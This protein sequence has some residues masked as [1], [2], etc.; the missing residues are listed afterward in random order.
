MQKILLI[1]AAV[2]V[3]GGGVYAGKGKLFTNKSDQDT[4]DKFIARAEKRDID[5]SVEVSGDVM[6][7]TQ[8][9][10][11]AEVGGKVKKM[12]VLPGQTV[13]KGDLLA[14]IDDSV[15]LTDKDGALTEIEGAKLAM[16]KAKRN[17]ERSRDLF[18][19]KLVSRELFD[20]TSSEFEIAENGLVK[21]QKKLQQ[22]EDQLH[23]AKVVAPSNGTILT[24]PVV[25]GQVIIAAASVNSGTTL[26]TI[27]DLRKLLV[28]TH[29]NQVDVARIELS[30]PV[31]L[32]AESL[33]DL[34]ME[35]TISF[36]APVAT[37]TNN[38]KGFD[39]QALIDKPSSRLRPGMTVNMT[40]PIARADDALSVPISAVFKGEG[41][42]KIVYVR[43][44]ETTEKREVKVGVTNIEH[45][46]ILQGVSEGEEILLV[47]P[48]KAQKRS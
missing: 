47:E 26:M 20:N 37:V 46:Q 48:D 6:P 14:E 28:Q 15:L 36:I 33:K 35:A 12:H 44:G 23:F 3:I 38:V 19:Q 24:V 42:K 21:A 11:K 25:E 18:E 1:L 5:L 30:Q 40:I 31:K 29:I 7:A 22:V 39:V 17:Y 45:A 2:A 4:P 13:K 27:A 34:E 43:K 41:N 8:L 10:V 16:E 9:D 32:R